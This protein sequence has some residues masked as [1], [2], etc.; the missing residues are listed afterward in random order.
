MRDAALADTNSASASSE[1]LFIP[2]HILSS[3]LLFRLRR[4]NMSELRP[5]RIAGGL[6]PHMRCPTTRLD[7]PSPSFRPRPLESL[8]Q[9]LTLILQKWSVTYAA[10][11]AFAVSRQPPPAQARSRSE[12]LRLESLVSPALSQALRRSLPKKNPQ[13][14]RSP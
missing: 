8:G 6:L 11:L 1:I 7:L 9:N 2:S 12:L 5:V 3:D 4:T 10:T 14:H 13:W